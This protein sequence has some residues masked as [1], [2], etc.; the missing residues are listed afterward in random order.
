VRRS[1]ILA[2]AILACDPT[3]GPGLAL[4]MGS[5]CRVIDFEV[6]D[7]AVLPGWKVHAMAVERSGGDSAWTLATDPGGHLLLQP[8]PAGPGLELSGVGLPGQFTLMPGPIEGQAWLVLDRDDRTQVWRLDDAETGQLQVGPQLPP[9]P[10]PGAWRRRLVFVEQA[11]YLLA[12]P[13]LADAS[14]IEVQLAPLSTETLS[15][16]APTTLEFW[17]TCPEDQGTGESGDT[18]DTDDTGSACPPSLITGEVTVEPLSTTEPGATSVSATL[19]AMYGSRLSEAD[20]AVYTTLV[21]SLEL[22]SAG[23]DQ[24]P[25]MVRRDHVPWTTVGEVAVAPA[26]ITVDGN[27]LFVL[28]GLTPV[29]EAAPAPTFDYLIRAGRN[30]GARDNAIMATFPKPL[31]SNLLQLGTRVALLQRSPGGDKLYI[32]PV[33]DLKI[34]TGKAGSLAIDASAEVLP[35]GRGQLLV[36]GESLSRRVISGCASSELENE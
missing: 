19:I 23:P 28:A 27:G 9:L 14:L 34:D 26:Q 17:R 8:W 13:Q 12:V 21:A 11:A 5:I 20:T 4:D 6:R 2:A 22:I 29:L 7:P 33:G 16:A 3:V 36:R 10:G 25:T 32:A 31:D 30:T 24:P 15:P 35:A 18:G 1:L